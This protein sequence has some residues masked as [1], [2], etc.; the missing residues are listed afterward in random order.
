VAA[1]SA[2]GFK[3]GDADEAVRRA[4]LALGPDATTESLVKKALA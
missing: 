1:L 4:S 3:I 2:L